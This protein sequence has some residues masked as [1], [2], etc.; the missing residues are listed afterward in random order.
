MVLGTLNVLSAVSFLLIAAA[1]LAIIFGV[2]QVVNLAHGEFIMMGAYTSYLVV[3]A[4]LPPAA[5]LL[6]APV[7]VGAVG[8][9]L[10]PIFFRFL[11]GKMMESILATWGLSIV[12][13]QAAQLIFGG[14]Y[15][16]VPYAT[17]ASVSVFG[18]GYSVYRLLALVLALGLVIGL[19]LI[20]RRTNLGTTARAVISDAELASSLGVNVGR[21]YMGTL[22]AGAALAGLAGAFLAPLTSAYPTMGLS[23][24]TD[25][26]FVVLVGGLGSLPGLIF[27]SSVLGGTK[28]IVAILVDPVWGSVALVVIALILVRIRRA[29]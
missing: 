10:E 9:L 26:F 12:L 7:V 6:I 18:T 11:Y 8:L 29:A 17:D 20:E 14:G 19:I 24:L 2:M 23:F 5:S 3:Q 25:S 15:L 13:R 27:S 16:A 21:F 28:Q 4:G 22:A 1:G